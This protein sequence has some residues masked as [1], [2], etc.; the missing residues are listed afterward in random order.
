MNEAVD[1]PTSASDEGEVAWLK[2]Q[3]GEQGNEIG[4]LRASLE[5][6][7]DEQDRALLSES[8]D[9]DQ[10]AAMERAMESK[11]RPVQ[12]QLQAA[13]T[14]AAVSKL[15]AKHPDYE[16]VVQQPQFQE[17][18][19]SSRLNTSAF[20]K[21]IQGDIDTGIEL[22]DTYKAT[23]QPQQSG[24]TMKAALASSRGSSG[25][26]GIREGGTISRA[27]LQHLKMTDPAGYRAKLP[28][29]HKAYAEGRVR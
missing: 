14:Q 2:K 19:K 23:V 13:E 11:L 27:E 18:V 21:A 4:R 8:F 16:Q 29:I 10:L 20:E 7:I 28:E 3:L 5:A 15:S 1:A 17:W 25:D 22:L 9:S 26:A 6:K 24:D 12:E